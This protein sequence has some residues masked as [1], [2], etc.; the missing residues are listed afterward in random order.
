MSGFSSL[1]VA[2]FLSQRAITRGNRGITFLTVALMAVIYA[3]LLFVP[4]LIQ[5]ATNQIQLEFRQNVTSNM[6]ITPIGSD[7]TIPHPDALIAQARTTRDVLA[8]AAT[9]LAGSQISY[10][11]RSNSWPV[12]AID[13]KSYAQTFATPHSMVEGSFLDPGVNNEIVLGIGIAGT[14]RMNVATF[15]SSLQ[16]VRVGDKVNVTLQGGEIHRFTVKGIYETDL[17]QA[18]TTAFITAATIRQLIPSA[19]GEASTIFVKTKQTGDENRV[20]EGLRRE[21]HDVRYQSW[22][23]LSLAVKDITGSFDI[24]KSILNAVSLFVAAI[25]VFIVTYV[26]LI[27]RRRTMGIERAIGIS[28]PAIT[29]SY[30]VKAIAF[31]LVGVVLGAGLFFSIAIPLVNHFPFQFP[32]GPVTLSVTVQELRQDAMIL[33]A[34]ALIG[35]VVPAWRAVRTRLLTAIWG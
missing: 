34:V 14:G 27:N 20:I 11:N 26:D 8:V 12:L 10:G 21:R 16:T 24:I 30:G 1:R 2:T 13:P 25:T 28:G 4:S 35:A 33:I 9:M 31:A 3:E 17:T 22:E 5:G 32:I 6:T 19:A 7:V 23:T 29:A 15:G 18:N